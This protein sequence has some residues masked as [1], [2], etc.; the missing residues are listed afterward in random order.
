MSLIYLIYTLI[1]N[2]RNNY[3]KPKFSLKRPSPLISRLNKPGYGP[4]S[5]IPNSIRT[6]ATTNQKSST[7]ENTYHQEIKEEEILQGCS[8]YIQ[9][10]K[11]SINNNKINKIKSSNKLTLIR[12]IL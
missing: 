11:I 4:F 1:N 8:L 6:K 12:K 2:H 5:R 10:N 9:S 3:P 7:N